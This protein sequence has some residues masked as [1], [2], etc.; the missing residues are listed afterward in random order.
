MDSAHVG[1]IVGALGT[2]EQHASGQGHSWWQRMRMLMIIIGP[3]LI[4]M[5]GDNDAGAVAT[6]SQAGQN[7][8]MALA[9][10]LALLIPVLYVNQEMV[11]RL[12]A[13]SGVGHAKLIFERFGKFWGWFSVGDLF[14][15]NTLTIVT[16]FI[17]V[18]LAL[19]FFGLPKIVGVPVAAVVLLL[20]VAGGSF[21]R[22]ERLLFTLIA[23]NIF[24][25]VPAVLFLA[26]PQSARSPAVCCRSSR[27]G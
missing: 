3:G 8:A 21:R 24:V 19:A 22:W 26:H 10:T 12:G 6:Y 25:V 23:V 4:V 5:V 27:V 14:V 17:G 15:L 11:L 20:I 18:T 2:I 16:E 9:W 1:D 7:C 13:V